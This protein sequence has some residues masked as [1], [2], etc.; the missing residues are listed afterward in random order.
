[1]R[2]AE[3]TIVGLTIV[4][5]QKPAESGTAH[6]YASLS[7]LDYTNLTCK[8]VALR[9]RVVALFRQKC[10]LQGVCFSQGQSIE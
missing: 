6:G 2:V 4:T 7:G 9:G 10:D 5:R 1:M 3:L 8:V